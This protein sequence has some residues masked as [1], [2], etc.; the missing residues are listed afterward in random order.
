MA[1]TNIDDSS[2]YFQTALYSGTGAT[3]KT[4]TNDGNS[5]LQTDV[6]IVWRVSLCIEF[7]PGQHESVSY[8]VPDMGACKRLA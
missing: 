3:R 8:S 1:Y 7:V 5:N 6:C 2:A 4:V